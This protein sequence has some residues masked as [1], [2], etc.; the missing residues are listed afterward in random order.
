MPLPTNTSIHLPFLVTNNGGYHLLVHGLDSTA[1][2]PGLPPSAM[3]AALPD[4]NGDLVP[5]LI[6]GAPGDDETNTNAGRVFVSFGYSATVPTAQLETNLTRLITIDGASAGDLA[7]FAVGSIADLNGDGLAEILVGAP[8]MEN[9]AITDAGGAFVVWGRNVA[10]DVSLSKVVAGLGDGFAMLGEAAQDHV[11]TALVS[12]SDLNGDGLSEIFVNATGNDAGGAEAGAAYVVWGSSAE[13]PIN[14]ANVAAGS[15]G[16]RIIGQAAGDGASK[17][18]GTVADLNGDGKVELLIGAA[19]NDAGGANAGAVYVV[20]GKATGT[21]VDLDAIA[22]GAGGF[23]ITGVAGE[24]AGTSVTGLGDVNGDGRGDILLTAPGSGK[25]Y[26]VFGKGTNTNVN[27]ATLA[28]SGEGFVIRP[29]IASDLEGMNVAAGGDFN[30]DGIADYVIGVPKNDVGGTDLGAVYVVWGG[31]HSTIDLSLVGS[32]IGGVMI[33]GAPNIAGFAVGAGIGTSV[34]TL[35]DMNGDGTPDILISNP[36]GASAQVT[37]LFSP[38]SWQP[39]TNVYGSNDADVLGPGDGTARLIGNGNDE[40]YGFAGD[41]SIT[42]AGGDDILN[43]GSGADNLIGGA[44]NDS[45]VVD[46]F[47][48]RVQEAIGGGTDTVAV[49]ANWAMDANVENLTMFGGNAIDVIG[50]ALDN[51]MVGNAAANRLDGGVGADVLIGNGGNDILIGGAGNDILDGS[52]GDNTLTGGAGNDRL[53]GASGTTATFSGIAGDYIVTNLGNGRLTI[54]DQR[55]GSPDGTD[56]A[57]A[58]MLLQFSVPATNAPPVITSNGG[59]A[60][61]AL[62]IAENQTAV[63]A[64]GVADPDSSVFTYALSGADAN[65]FQIDGSGNLRFIAAPNF[66]APSDVGAN[67][68]YDVII[69]VSDNGS[70]ILSDTQ[71]LAVSVTDVNE[72]VGVTLIGS[73]TVNDILNGGAGD[74]TLDGRALNDTLNGN[75]GNDTLLGGSGND[76]LNGG[77][78]ND[79]MTGGTGNDIYHVD[80]S[81]DTVIETGTLTTEIDTVNVSLLS[82][83]TLGANVERLVRIGTGDFSATGNA[84]ANVMTGASA[85]DTLIGLDGNDTLNGGV[86]SDIL[87]GGNGNDVLNGGSENDVLTGNDGADTLDGGTGADNLTGGNGNDIYVIDNISDVIVELAPSVPAPPAGTPTPGTDTVRTSLSSFTLGVTATSANVEHLTYT[88][89]AA[90]VG[91]GT[92]VSNT[93]IGGS[94]GDSLSGGAGDD[95]FAGGAG[96]DTIDGGIGVDRVTYASVAAGNSINVLLG[97]SPTDGRAN[98]DGTGAI[99][100]LRNIENITGS[101]G[102][103]TIIG[104]SSANI[105]EGGNG[106]DSI[107]GGAGN[108]TLRGA[109]GID[110]IN[111]DGGND[112]LDGGSGA[113]TLAGGLGDDTYIDS[114]ASTIDPLTPDTIIELAGEGI[115]T[116]QTSRTSVVL[117]ATLENLRFTGSLS[118]N[119]TGNAAAN[120]ITGGVAADILNG[121]DGNDTLRGGAGNDQLIGGTGNDSLNGEAGDDTLNGGMGIDALSGSTGNDVFIFNAADTFTNIDSIASWGNVVGNDD[122]IQLDDVVFTGLAVGALAATAFVSGAN[123]LDAAD[124]IIYNATTGA[125]YFDSDG[126]GASAQLQFGTLTP[127]LIL[128]NGDFA[129]V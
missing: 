21:Q 74:D 83:Y 5:E 108:D 59:G 62:S 50:N 99:D 60:S 48:D 91:V 32:G 35:P 17:S 90:F 53:D 63:T 46:D 107:S 9:G 88:G 11:G 33:D 81:G 109:A 110:T 120:T 34:A 20:F 55:A 14:L 56:D 104:N 61:A 3:V 28:G 102:N 65:R 97:D 49:L 47:A 15:G 79:A 113:D 27:L 73:D 101:S 105:L 2:V 69:T 78:N 123:A 96:A 10:S 1:T 66:E 52:A 58:T 103:D 67:N 112:T 43:G 54:A 115:D 89:T 77:A 68:I 39:E 13:T 80:S 125:L 84:L 98:N 40:V 71:A 122:R 116:L 7:G 38:V 127:G 23:R 87:Q 57:V 41:D 94:A 129:I 114:A 8:M 25:A 86:G 19:G 117:G 36:V 12:V 82:T 126:I 85:A 100:I 76:T 26:V 45:Y 93:L 30:R 124:R 22:A 119:G 64:L 51:Q 29:Q 111:G 31:N 4:L 18:L 16:F 70:P 6:L 72:T 121:L 95:L 92:T 42:T 128:T 75:G 24:N 118:F 106:N 37:V 44:G